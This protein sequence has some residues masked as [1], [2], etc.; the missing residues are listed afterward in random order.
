MK[1]RLLEYMVC[2]LCRRRL[3]L[4]HGERVQGEFGETIEEGM[5][6]CT[7]CGHPF[8][9]EAGIPVMLSP[10]LPRYNE[11][12]REA[13]G[14]VAISRDGG[15]YYPDER[16][17]MALPYVVRELGWTLEVGAGWTATALS[18]D[19]MVRRYVRPGMRI[20]EIGAAR[21][22]AGRYLTE[23]GCEYIACDL[24]TDPNIGL[25]RSRFFARQS[26]YF[27]V[28]A[29]DAEYLP[30]ADETFDLVFAIAALHHALDLDMMM[31]EMA[32]VC[33]QR[34]VVAGLNEG[35]RAF[36]SGPD[37][38]T[39]EKE[40]TY[41]INEHVYSLLDYTSAFWKAGLTPVDVTRAIGYE[42]LIS[43][44]TGKRARQLEQ[45]PI[46]GRWL[47]SLAVLGYAHPYDGVT[48]YAI[49]R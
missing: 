34:G 21:A 10:L 38:E 32:R 42:M 44:Q 8:V 23:M 37:A 26:G 18:F 30:F 2:P 43:E 15:W 24:V 5:L 36:L 27:E 47:A 12:M 33:R 31:A 29:A 19:E 6:V 49:K 13:R 17:D 39:Q 16:I 1:D 28:A 3:D 14:W 25:G 11:K 22:W 7:G 46:A 48:L 40:K 20:L 35:V 45:I 9:I 4:V 41:G